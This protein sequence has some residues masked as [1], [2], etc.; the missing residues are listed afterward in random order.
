VAAFVDLV[1]QAGH[2]GF[3]VQAEH[4]GGDACWLSVAADGRRGE[5]VDGTRDGQQRWLDARLA[6]STGDDPYLAHLAVDYSVNHGPTFARPSSDALRLAVI[7]SPVPPLTPACGAERR[8]R[9]RVAAHRPLRRQPVP[10]RCRQPA[11]RSG[12]RGGPCLVAWPNQHREVDC[13]PPVMVT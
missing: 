5:R 10:G 2:A 11:A 4:A 6:V 9:P 13:T 12:V 3:E 1:G 8:C 7:D